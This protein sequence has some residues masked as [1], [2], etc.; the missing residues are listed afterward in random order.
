MPI[1]KCS[2]APLG[3][4]AI[5][6][7]ITIALSGMFTLPPPAVLKNIATCLPLQSILTQGLRPPNSPNKLMILLLMSL[8]SPYSYP[9]LFPW[10]ATI[11]LHTTSMKNGVPPLL[12]NKQLISEF[13]SK[14]SAVKDLTK[15]TIMS[16]PLQSTSLNPHMMLFYLLSMGL[17]L[18]AS[19]RTYHENSNYHTIIIS[20]PTIAQNYN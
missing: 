15:M 18:P 8:M 16:N 10:L 2:K 19:S 3:T 13:L 12:P 9:M 7:C 17:T 4:S 6:L 5:A 14:I 20:L 1:P 11:P